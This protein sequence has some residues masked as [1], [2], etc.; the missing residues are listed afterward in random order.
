MMIEINSQAED[1]PRGIGDLADQLGL[2]ARELQKEQDTEAVLEDIVRAAIRLIPQV[3][4]ASISL[5]RARRTV[6]S[7]AASGDLPRRVDAVQS[8]TGQ[9]PCL[10]AAYEEQMVQVPDL[11]SETRWPRFARRAWD[12]GARSMLS[13]QLFVE[14][15]NL[16]ALN[17]YGA[18][19]G[20]FDEESE[21][22]G[23]LVAAHAAVAF[24]DAL[25]ISQ[26]NQALVNRDV[27]GQAKG[28]LMERF[29]VSAPQAFVLLSAVS[30]S[31]NTKLQVVAERLA[32]TGDIRLNGNGHGHAQAAAGG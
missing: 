16:G 21:Q 9:G 11:G 8:E 13:F 10:D 6:E 26:L 28:I 32:S 1:Q 31:T 7:R 20:A 15:D 29:K 12:L 3:E 2:L 23:Q 19:V 24:A 17:L 22:I 30:S 4:H 25:E 5:V 18:E 14:G 27:I